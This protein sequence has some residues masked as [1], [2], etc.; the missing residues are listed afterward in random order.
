VAPVKGMLFVQLVK[1]EDDWLWHSGMTC[2]MPGVGFGC[3][4]RLV[5]ESVKG[6]MGNIAGGGEP[7]AWCD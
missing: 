6:R 4:D 1:V 7:T 3:Y 2:C 5:A